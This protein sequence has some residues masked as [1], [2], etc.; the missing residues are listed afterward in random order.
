MTVSVPEGEEQ[1]EVRSSCHLWPIST[2]PVEPD[3]E[4]LHNKKESENTTTFTGIKRFSAQSGVS[5]FG[6]SLLKEKTDVILK[7]TSVCINTIK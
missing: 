4:T 5:R 2:A 7:Q 1:T 3:I 6:Y